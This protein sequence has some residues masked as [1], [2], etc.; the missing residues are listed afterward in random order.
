MCSSVVIINNGKIAATGPVSQ[1]S[2]S[3]G[4]VNKFMITLAADKGVCREA[5]DKV[6]E[7]TRAE[8]IRIDGDNSVYRIESKPDA[9]AR[10]TLFASLSA[11]EIPIMELRPIGKTLEEMFIE[12]VNKDAPAK[13]EELI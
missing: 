6:S 10:K 3:A 4:G 11:A 8:F 2:A 9:D 5:I 12:I 13:E 1:F 7:V